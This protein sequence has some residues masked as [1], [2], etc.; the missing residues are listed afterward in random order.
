[1]PHDDLEATHLVPRSEAAPTLRDVPKID[2]YR[3]V[4]KL[5]AGGMGE[6]FKAY[7]P[8]LGR[9]VAIKRVFGASTEREAQRLRREAQA[10]A[11]LSHP[12]VIAVF[13]VGTAGGELFMVMELVEGASLGRWLETKRPKVEAVLE[14]FLQCARGLAAAH[15]AGL[16]HRDFKPSNVLVG[17]DSRVRVLDFGL[18]RRQG[19]DAAVEAVELDDAQ[20][21]L[22]LD[23]TKPGTVAGTPRYMAR[24]QWLGKKV[25][26]RTDQFAFC[27]ALYEALT[28]RRP[29]A[30]EKGVA[31]LA[32]NVLAGRVLPIPPDLNLPSWL[33][34]LV[35]R[36]LGRTP[37]E[38]WPSMHDVIA[39][40]E[41]DRRR[42]RHA[43]T[44]GSS[45]EDLLAAF[46]PPDDDPTRERVLKLK[47]R[48]ER[49]AGLKK[50]GD[51]AAA[52]AEA[53]DVAREA[54]LVDY[55]PFQAASLYTLGNLQHRTGDAASARATL[56]RSA[57]RAARAGDDWQLANVWVFLVG[58]VGLGLGRFQEAE[59]L[60]QVAEVAIARVGD[61]PSLR[62][63]LLNAKARNLTAEGRAMEGVR[64]LEIAL[65]LDEDTHGAD[66]PLVAVT[67]ASVADALL[68]LDRAAVA[69]Q[70]LER[71][72]AICRK[73]N[74]RGPTYAT[75]LLLH[76]RALKRLG[77]KEQAL[78]SLEEARSRLSRYPDRL[79]DVAEAEDEIAKLKE[80]SG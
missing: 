77:F 45:T 4:S 16:V 9:L 15:D 1:M 72:L 61:N 74:K 17:N 40:L 27:V 30:A 79:P 18:A 48:L 57:E 60:A 69:R 23:L 5:G 67:L 34:A 76:G 51:F 25:D 80:A 39:E 65:A 78:Q 21:I 24:E 29:F 11:Q 42:L 66:H 36:G 3:I 20:V 6:V 41:Q 68:T 7:D 52:L 13:D 32:E 62:S 10:I 33:V 49:A 54:D 12:N 53:A 2:R 35:L 73:H 8:A 14:I 71:A 19:E 70:H 75:C 58:V 46:P 55:A 59:A 37:E 56:L 22:G 44:D 47:G 43:S 31:S 63:R 38:R 50:K 64:Q 26:G 28:F